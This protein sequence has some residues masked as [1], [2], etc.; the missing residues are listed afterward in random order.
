MERLQ[1]FLSS[2][3][4]IEIDSFMVLREVILY[5][6]Y[7]NWFISF[8]DKLSFPESPIILGNQQWIMVGAIVIALFLMFLTRGKYKIGISIIHFVFLTIVYGL[9]VNYRINF[10]SEA[11]VLPL[12]LALGKFHLFSIFGFMIWF[13]I[14]YTEI[15]LIKNTKI[16][17]ELDLGV[18]KLSKRH[19]TT[20]PIEVRTKYNFEPGD[21]LIWKE[22]NGRLVIEKK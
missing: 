3:F 5:G 12:R 2:D 18:V 9:E 13:L 10:S 17:S 14:V 20:V 4:N 19:Q 11:A 16:D 6:M 7:S 1:N 8:F 22:I 15:V 21:H